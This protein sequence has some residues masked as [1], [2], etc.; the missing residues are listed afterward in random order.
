MTDIFRLCV[1]I[2][3][4]L[5]IFQQLNR[6]D[7]VYINFL[8][9]YCVLN[10]YV[11]LLHKLT[12]LI[13]KKF[14]FSKR[15]LYYTRFLHVDVNLDVKCQLGPSIVWKNAV[16]PCGIE[17]LA[18]IVEK[19]TEKFVLTLTTADPPRRYRLT[20]CPSTSPIPFRPATY[21]FTSLSNVREQ[22]RQ[23]GVFAA[24]ARGAR[25]VS[26]C[27]RASIRAAKQIRPTRTRD[28]RRRGDAVWARMGD[29]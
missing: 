23:C 19:Y 25:G 24:V 7:L 11:N 13:G 1:T 21:K 4:N 6:M 12:R 29:S 10:S 26:A 8:C 5:S 16:I 28:K 3:I 2:L 15:R 17:V 22:R 9:Y 20:R 14:I 18:R 27:T